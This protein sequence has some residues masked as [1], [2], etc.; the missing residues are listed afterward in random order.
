MR[1]VFQEC[2]GPAL[3]YT[4]K[5]ALSK[6]PGLQQGANINS[7]T[8]QSVPSAFLRRQKPELIREGPRSDCAKAKFLKSLAEV[9]IQSRKAAEDVATQT[10]QC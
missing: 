8:A 1:T 5:A 3:P 7:K 9:T 6:G 2:T 4:V 10:S